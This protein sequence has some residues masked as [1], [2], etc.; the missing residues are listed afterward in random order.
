MLFEFLITSAPELSYRILEKKLTT[1]IH[2]SDELCDHVEQLNASSA[3]DRARL[4]P[5]LEF[6][7][8]D[9]DL[10]YDEAFQQYACSY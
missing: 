3:E 1:E 5:L 8:P 2:V 9:R 10:R 6:T 4:E 7:R